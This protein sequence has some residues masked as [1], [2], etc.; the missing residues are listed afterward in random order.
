R[1]PFNQGKLADA[2]RFGIISAALMLISVLTE[3]LPG[4]EGLFSIR[5]CL[6]LGSLILLYRAAK[7]IS[8]SRPHDYRR[9][10]GFVFHR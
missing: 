9:A 7:G 3:H 1:N 10:G 8:E 6:G 2:R 5:A 4:G